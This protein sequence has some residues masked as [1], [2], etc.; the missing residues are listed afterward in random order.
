MSKLASPNAFRR[1]AFCGRRGCLPSLLGAVIAGIT[2]L[3]L[4]AAG[5]A[6]ELRARLVNKTVI[7]GQGPMGLYIGQVEIILPDG[8][9]KL[10]PYWSY[11]QPQ[12]VKDRVFILSSEGLSLSRIFIYDARRDKEESFRLP[13]DLD[14]LWGSPS[15]S[16]DGRKIA[17][18]LVKEGRV[19][20]RTWP[21][22]SM[23]RKS[24]SY[25]V[26]A[27]EVPPEPPRWKN[28]TTVVFDPWFFRPARE[29]NFN[30]AP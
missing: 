6:A 20:V 18:Y 22:L 15:F 8:Q 10:L 26:R 12:V 14:P 29:I 30:L 17:Y 9:T 4:V 25:P 27:L 19:V 7:E 3:A 1:S 11:L 23:L 5:T 24:P 13:L 16:P 2:L 21:A 28:P